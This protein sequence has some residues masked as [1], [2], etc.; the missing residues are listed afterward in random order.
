MPQISVQLMDKKTIIVGAIP[1]RH[2][3]EYVKTEIQQKENIPFDQQVLIF[4]GQKLDDKN[5]LSKYNVQ[6]RSTLHLVLREKGSKTY[7]RYKIVILF[8]KR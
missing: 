4:Q 3:V 1:T 6:E 8:Y 5:K 2:T 7:S